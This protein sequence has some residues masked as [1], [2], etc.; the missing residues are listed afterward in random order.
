MNVKGLDE[1]FL[2]ARVASGAGDDELKRR[3]WG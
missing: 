1:I 2:S 3:F